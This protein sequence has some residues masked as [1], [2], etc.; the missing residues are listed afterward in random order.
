MKLTKSKLKQIIREEVENVAENV[1]GQYLQAPRQHI[2]LKPMQITPE[3]EREARLQGGGDDKMVERQ[4]EVMIRD[5]L[6]LA[7][8][9]PD[10]YIRDA[11]GETDMHDMLKG[12]S[13][14]QLSELWRQTTTTPLGDSYKRRRY[15][16]RLIRK[17]LARYPDPPETS[18]DPVDT[19]AHYWEN[20]EH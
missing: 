16:K 5:I 10:P 17:A 14:K 2:E 6:H 20:K 8:S 13:D 3:E 19:G 9:E 15:F 4:R 11:Q 1:L 18:R 12:W 7:A